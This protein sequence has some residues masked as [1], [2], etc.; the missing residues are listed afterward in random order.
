MSTYFKTFFQFQALA[1]ITEGRRLRAEQ[2]DS[3]SSTNVQHDIQQDH[4][5]T[6]SPV[7]EQP[8]PI[9]VADSILTPNQDGIFSDSAVTGDTVS[10]KYDYTEMADP[11]SRSVSP[12]E[13]LSSADETNF[14]RSNTHLSL[15]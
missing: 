13:W 8:E 7:S 9:S 15:Q 6:S 10:S 12:G 2:F 11:T 3:S 5:G 14:F 4:V 1:C